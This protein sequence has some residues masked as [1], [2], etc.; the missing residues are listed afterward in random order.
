M[1]TDLGSLGTKRD[2]VDAEPA[3]RFEVNG[4]DEA[5]ADDAGANL[6]GHG[7]SPVTHTECLA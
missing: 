2:D 4:A 3:Q 5:G 6:I 7:F 1:L